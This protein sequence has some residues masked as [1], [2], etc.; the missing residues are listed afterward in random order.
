MLAGVGLL[1]VLSGRSRAHLRAHQSQM[2]VAS[3]VVRRLDADE[4]GH[5]RSALESIDAYCSTPLRKK[6]RSMNGAEK[7]PSDFSQRRSG[8]ACLPTVPRCSWPACRWPT[9]RP[10]FSDQPPP[11]SLST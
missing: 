3:I 1:W 6:P 4:F 8:N 7:L 9:A 10:G 5:L 2:R 11:P